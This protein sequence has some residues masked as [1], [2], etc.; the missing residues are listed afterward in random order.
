MLA[1]GRNNLAPFARKTWKTRLA[2]RGATNYLL[3][4]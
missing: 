3:A 1:A 4:S 2:E